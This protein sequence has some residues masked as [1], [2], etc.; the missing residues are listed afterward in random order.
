M[1]N[2]FEDPRKRILNKSFDRGSFTF[3]P[4]KSQHTPLH[5]CSAPSEAERN[6]TDIFD[7]S[8]VTN[9]PLQI[10]CVSDNFF[11]EFLQKP[12]TPLYVLQTQTQLSTLHKITARVNSPSGTNTPS[13]YNAM[14]RTLE[15]VWGVEREKTKSRLGEKKSRVSTNEPAPH[16]FIGCW[17]IARVGRN[18]PTEPETEIQRTW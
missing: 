11:H 3:R 7:N 8:R 16:G 5:T 2:A 17:C 10:E 12:S 6:K 15:N 1:M 9:I 4:L 13:I 18:E 14:L